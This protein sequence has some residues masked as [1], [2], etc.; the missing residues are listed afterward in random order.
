[1]LTN[2]TL[3]TSGFFLPEKMSTERPHALGLIT[4]RYNELLLD[5]MLKALNGNHRE[6][7]L[8]I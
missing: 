8:S 3:H 6:K 5:V 1:M 7:L 4:S 2:A